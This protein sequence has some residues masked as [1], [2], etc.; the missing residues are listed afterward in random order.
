MLFVVLLVF[1][2]F[3]VRVCLA[4]AICQVS[5][6][7]YVQYFS[8]LDDVKFEIMGTRIDKN[9]ENNTAAFSWLLR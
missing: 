4:F 6:L 3:T 9:N 2:R 1:D 7:V 5:F 8:L